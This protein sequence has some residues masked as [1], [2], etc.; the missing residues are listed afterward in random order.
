M[1]TCTR[2]HTSP[3]S[4]HFPIRLSAKPGESTVSMA[5]RFGTATNFFTSNAAARSLGSFGSFGRRNLA[6][7]GRFGPWERHILW[8]FLQPPDLRNCLV[9]KLL[10]TNRTTTRLR[11]VKLRFARLHGVRDQ[12]NRAKEKQKTN[13]LA[14]D[15]EATLRRHEMFQGIKTAGVPD[16]CPSQVRKTRRWPPFASVGVSSCG[17]PTKK[18]PPKGLEHEVL[19]IQTGLETLD[20]LIFK[21]LSVARRPTQMLH[22]PKRAVNLILE[23]N[24]RRGPQRDHRFEQNALRSLDSNIHSYQKYHVPSSPDTGSGQ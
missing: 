24:R 22:L 13:Q 7:H 21:E 17:D 23:A 9:V 20:L 12:M 16:I 11:T 18:Q 3:G 4:S 1:H 8:A 15:S 19:W 2:T 6:P 5:T 10:Q 14:K